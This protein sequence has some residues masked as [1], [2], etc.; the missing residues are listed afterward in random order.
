VG[1][2]GLWISRRAFNI[3]SRV[4]STSFGTS[5][6]VRPSVGIG[7]RTGD[8]LCSFQLWSEITFDFDVSRFETCLAIEEV[9]VV[10]AYYRDDRYSGYSSA[11][12]CWDGKDVHCTAR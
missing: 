2:V 7:G 4:C 5:A 6:D 1:P 8:Q 12:V 3:A 9:V 10:L 11:G